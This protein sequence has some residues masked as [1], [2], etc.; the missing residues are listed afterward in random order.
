MKTNMQTDIIIYGSDNNKIPVAPTHIIRMFNVIASQYMTVP[1]AY[2][3]DMIRF[4][5]SKNY[6]FK[7]RNTNLYVAFAIQYQKAE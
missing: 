1:A 6:V 4:L 3:D 7:T 5:K 2:F